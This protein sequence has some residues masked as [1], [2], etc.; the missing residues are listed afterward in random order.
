MRTCVYTGW[1]E[2]EEMTAVGKQLQGQ[3][4]LC[5]RRH[6]Q[7]KQEDSE[8]EIWIVFQLCSMG[9]IVKSCFKNNLNTLGKAEKLSHCNV[10]I[11]SSLN[12]ISCSF[13]ILHSDLLFCKRFILYSGLT[14]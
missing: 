8:D 2:Y 4:F 1:E 7:R 11:F 10:L 5:V 6:I 12:F 13:F 3:E 14:S 9:S